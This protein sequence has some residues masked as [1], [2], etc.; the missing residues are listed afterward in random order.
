[1]YVYNY[2]YLCSIYKYVYTMY[3]YTHMCKY[4]YVHTFNFIHRI[5]KADCYF[6]LFF[7]LRNH[8]TSMNGKETY[9]DFT[10]PIF[11]QEDSKFYSSYD[12]VKQMVK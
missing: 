12:N 8:T 2:T 7:P 4:T 3:T 6:D 5:R 9:M 11:T 10:N 1:M